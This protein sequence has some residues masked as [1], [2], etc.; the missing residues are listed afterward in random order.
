[1]LQLAERGVKSRQISFIFVS[2][3]VFLQH[4]ISV[5]VCSCICPAERRGLERAGRS[6]LIIHAACKSHS[7][8][9]KSLPNSG[10]VDDDGLI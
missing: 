8:D 6:I 7:R 3:F 2:V 1:M 4:C 9:V 5:R 10:H